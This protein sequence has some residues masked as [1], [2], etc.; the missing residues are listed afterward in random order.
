MNI[1][2]DFFPTDLQSI[3]DFQSQLSQ[4]QLRKKIYVL[5]LVHK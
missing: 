5:V 2:N 3:A 1:T 4:T